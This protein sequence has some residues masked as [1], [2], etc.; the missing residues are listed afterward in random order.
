MINATLH[1][2]AYAH[3]DLEAMCGHRRV[4]WVKP[5]P[6]EGYHAQIPLRHAMG[7]GD[8]AGRWGDNKWRNER[9]KYH[10]CETCEKLRP[11]TILNHAVL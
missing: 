10:M 3:F 2:V 6:V 4:H 8:W 1:L 9:I 7:T 11:L 5:M